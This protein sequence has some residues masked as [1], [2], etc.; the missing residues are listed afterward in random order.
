MSPHSHPEPPL[1]QP[2]AIPSNPI[3]DVISKQ[4][5]FA[6]FVLKGKCAEKAGAGKE[7]K[8]EIE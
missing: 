5:I 4:S 2:D 8:N 7:K 6:Q 3:Q 1:A